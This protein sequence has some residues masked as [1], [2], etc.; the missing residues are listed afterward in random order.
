MSQ[1][2]VLISVGA[3][4]MLGPLFVDSVVG[5]HLNENRLRV[6]ASTSWQGEG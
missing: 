2:W 3:L 1:G 4:H 5:N 6:G